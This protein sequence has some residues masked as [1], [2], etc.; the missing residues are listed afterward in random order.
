MGRIFSSTVLLLIEKKIKYIHSRP[1]FVVNVYLFLDAAGFAT[2]SILSACFVR[3]SF[4][5]ASRSLEWTHD[6]RGQTR[7]FHGENRQAFCVRSLG[8]RKPLLRTCQRDSESS[9]FCCSFSMLPAARSHLWPS[10][11]A[12]LPSFL[13]LSRVSF[14]AYSPFSH[15]ISPSLQRNRHKKKPVAAVFVLA[16]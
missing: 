4:L 3:T 7:L 1:L 2:Q 6:A 11:C 9:L 8:V 14:L 5:H 12:A 13:S 10:G 16:G 15:Q